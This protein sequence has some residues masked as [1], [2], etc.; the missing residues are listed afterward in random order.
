[1]LPFLLVGDD[2]EAGDLGAGA[3]GGGDGDQF[4][5]LAQ[6]RELER[7]L[8]DVQEALAQAVEAG[9]RMLVEQPHALGRVDGRAAADGDDDVRLEGVHG[10][11]AAHDA[12]NGRIALHVGVDLAVAVLLALAQVVQH[13]VHVAQLHHHRVGDDE[14]AG[15][16]LHLFQVLDGILLKIDLGGTLNHCMLT[17]LLAMR[18]LLMRF[19]VVTFWDTLFL[20]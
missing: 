12:L 17:L 18:F 14:R 1:M 2:G 11:D 9:V 4:G 13:L 15:D 6:F 3:G 20:P 16:V 5:L 10:L 19:T 8:A 7:T